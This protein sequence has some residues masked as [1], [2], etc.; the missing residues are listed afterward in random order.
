[1]AVKARKEAVEAMKP[2]KI[3]TAGDRVE[4]EMLLEALHRNHIQGFRE[5]PGSGG[6]M[7]VYTGNSIYG[8]KIYVDELDASRAMEIIESVLS[9]AELSTAPGDT[10]ECANASEM[11]YSWL[12][13]CNDSSHRHDNRNRSVPF[14]RITEKRRHLTYE[15]GK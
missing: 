11:G 3:Y 8:E 1:M 14:Y 15:E 4:A 5:A 7:D 10:K 12:F 13:D 9:E 6:A 2:V